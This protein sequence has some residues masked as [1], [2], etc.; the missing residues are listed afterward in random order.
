[1]Q[2]S[3]II[4]DR[5]M[6]WYSVNV[7]PAHVQK[8]MLAMPCVGI[9]QYNLHRPHLT[10]LWC[11]PRRVH[12]KKMP[13]KIPVDLILVSVAKK[14]RFKTPKKIIRKILITLMG[15]TLN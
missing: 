7:K 11:R 15:W 9:C 8:H 6:Y 10:C 5:H 1:M 2:H 13:S 12:Y 4:L 14:Q 3:T